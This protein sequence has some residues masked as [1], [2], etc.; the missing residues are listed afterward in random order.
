MASTGA[1]LLW[2]WM[3]YSRSRLWTFQAET[4]KATGVDLLNRIEGGR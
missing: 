2:L 4:G 3:R 1:R